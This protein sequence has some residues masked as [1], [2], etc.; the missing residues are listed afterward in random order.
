MPLYDYC[1]KQGH[2]TESRQGVGIASIP[3]P[4]CQLTAQRM[5]VYA[6]QYII[7]ATG[8]KGVPS[9]RKDR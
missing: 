5:A 7:C 1:C 9:A 6:E 4:K 8:P 3:C 2:V